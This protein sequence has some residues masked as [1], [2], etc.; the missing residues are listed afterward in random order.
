M[1]KLGS[2]AK[3]DADTEPFRDKLSMTETEAQKHARKMKKALCG[4]LKGKEKARCEKTIRVLPGGR[5]KTRG[6]KS[7]RRTRRRGTRASRKRPT[8]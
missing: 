1:D 5:R 6:G 3:L 7:R 8:R 4:H 2:I